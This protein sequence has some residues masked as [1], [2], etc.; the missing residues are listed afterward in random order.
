MPEPHRDLNEQLALV[1][2]VD[3][4]L[5]KGA[6]IAGDVVIAVSGVDLVRL[7]LQVVLGSV[8]ALTRSREPAAAKETRR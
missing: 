4:V 6:V 2:L 7:E 3:R 5:G 1:E 8:D